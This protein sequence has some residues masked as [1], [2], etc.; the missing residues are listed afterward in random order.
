MADNIAEYTIGDELDN[1][2]LFWLDS[3]GALIDFS[4]GYT[5]TVTMTDSKGNNQFT[6]KT[7][8]ITGAA[9][10]LATDTPNVVVAWATSSEISSIADPGIYNFFC[11]ARRSA[12]N[13][14]RT[15][16]GLIRLVS[17]T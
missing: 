5:Y 7:S 13:K 8:G 9:G 6:A 2:G 14:D 4:S 17:N 15:F 1:L 3:T 11:R 12:D 16:R 10:S